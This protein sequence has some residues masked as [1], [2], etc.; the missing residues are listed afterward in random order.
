MNATVQG[1]PGYGLLI[2]QTSTHCHCVDWAQELVF[3]Q[4]W[5]WTPASNLFQGL[6]GLLESQVEWQEGDN[7]APQLQVSP[8]ATQIQEQE[9][10]IWLYSRERCFPST[11]ES[12]EGRGE[13]AKSRDGVIVPTWLLFLRQFRAFNHNDNSNT[14][15]LWFNS[16]CISYLIHIDSLN[17]TYPEVHCVC[18]LETSLPFD[19]NPHFLEIFLMKASGFL[20]KQ[21]SYMNL[22]VSLWFPA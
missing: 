15:N 11:S 3:I 19:S 18:Q 8:A 20:A 9:S 13:E 7:S 12:W 22:L 10:Q 16:H 1:L 6:E 14:I 2:S 21:T 5:L 4:Q 17:F